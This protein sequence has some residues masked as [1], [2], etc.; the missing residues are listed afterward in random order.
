MLKTAR[1]N[2]A[3]L[4]DYDENRRSLL[5]EC[6]V[7]TRVPPH[8]RLLR[9]Y[10]FSTTA[11]S[12]SLALEYAPHGTLRSYIKSRS[13]TISHRQ[14]SKWCMQAV[15]A[16]SILHRNGVVHGDV[17]PDNFLVAEDHSLRIVGF[18]GSAIDGQSGNG[19]EAARY[20]M[21]RNDLT[22]AT[23]DSDRF[24][25]G[26]CFYYIMTGREPHADLNRAQAMAAFANQEY[27]DVADLS[28]G[29]IILRCWR[30][31]YAS[32]AAIYTDLYSLQL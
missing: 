22:T 13:S 25:L 11:A 14:R 17:R 28:I 16:L 26:S 30:G 5:R 3:N 27:P 24:A 18:G 19:V 31:E 6:D 10:G 15:E 21:P 32:E 23:P 9:F 7:Y 1:P 20:F 2:G 12:S 4:R 29:D 8:S